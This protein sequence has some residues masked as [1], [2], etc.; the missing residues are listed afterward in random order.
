M[1]TH[2]VISTFA[3]ENYSKPILLI[4]RNTSLRRPFCFVS[5]WIILLRDSE[6]IRLLETTRSLNEYIL[7]LN[8]Y[9]LYKCINPT[10]FLHSSRSFWLFLYLPTKTL[11]HFQKNRSRK[12]RFRPEVF[13]NNFKSFPD[14]LGG[15]WISP[16]LLRQ[17][18]KHDTTL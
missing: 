1:Y 5:R 7:K 15:S 16:R 14:G 8:S 4:S 17:S 10:I 9:N 12:C 11:K 3:E 18:T 13:S 6:L 2:K